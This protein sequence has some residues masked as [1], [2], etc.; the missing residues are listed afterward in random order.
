MQGGREDRSSR[1]LRKKGSK[2]C[3][4]SI[5]N[6][7]GNGNGEGDVG[8]QT[9]E[10][11]RTSPWSTAGRMHTWSEIGVVRVCIVIAHKQQLLMWHICQLCNWELLEKDWGKFRNII[12]WQVLWT[13]IKTF[14]LNS[15]NKMCY[16]FTKPAWLKTFAWEGA[17]KADAVFP[18]D[19]KWSLQIIAWHSN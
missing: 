18:K 15:L 6:H 17:D 14:F 13:L 1:A 2:I 7:M 19:F 11:D 9:E 10:Q 3:Q 4:R 5:R 8:I 16:T 12:C